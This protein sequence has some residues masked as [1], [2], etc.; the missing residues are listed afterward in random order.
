IRLTNRADRNA[1]AGEMASGNVVVKQS[2]EGLVVSLREI[3]FFRQRFRQIKPGSAGAFARLAEILRATNHDIRIEGPSD[4]VPIHNIRFSSHWDRS[5]AQAT[6]TVR[7]LME[8]ERLRPKWLG[9]S[10]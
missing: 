5:T 4:D 8:S 1:L 7:L 2:G 10:G 3:G 6:A 9:A